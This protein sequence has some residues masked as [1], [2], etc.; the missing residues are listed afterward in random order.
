LISLAGS[1][2][3]KVKRNFW[4]EGQYPMAL[5]GP[6]SLPPC[7]VA[8]MFMTF[9]EPLYRPHVPRAGPTTFMSMCR[10]NGSF[11]D[12]WSDFAIPVLESTQRLEENASGK[13]PTQVMQHAAASPSLPHKRFPPF[14]ENTRES[15]TGRTILPPSAPIRSITYLLV[16]PPMLSPPGS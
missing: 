13:A 4:D 12:W 7:T 15:A 6:S 10:G 8:A 9:G 11:H 2:T 14:L 5:T 1:A 16:L 3:G